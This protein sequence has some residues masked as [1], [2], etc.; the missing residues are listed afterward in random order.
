MKN[1]SCNAAI[2]ERFQIE[3]GALHAI[4]DA[5]TEGSAFRKAMF[6]AKNITAQN[7]SVLARFRIVIVG[8]GNKIF[9][10]SPWMYQDPHELLKTK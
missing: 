7:L 9:K 8:H 1:N 10:R 2:N 3:C 6:Q 4:V 5:R